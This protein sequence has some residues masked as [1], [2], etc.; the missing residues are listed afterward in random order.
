MRVPFVTTVSFADGDGTVHLQYGISAG[1][2][3]EA[4]N[5]IKRRLINQELYKYSI[6]EIRRATSTEAAS[7]NLSPG[8][9][10]LLN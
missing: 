5:E 9:I 1:D 2:E 4:R 10:K 8:T 3:Q 7:L 6:S